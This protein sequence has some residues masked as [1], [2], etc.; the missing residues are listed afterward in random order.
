M[1]VKKNHQSKQPLAGHLTLGRRGEALAADYLTKIGFKI[2]ERNLRTRY[3]EIDLVCLDRQI[4]VFVEVKTRSS[5]SYAAPR[6]AVN[7]EKRRHLSKA[8]LWFI[9]QKAWEDRSARFDVVEISF[10]RPQAEINH[11]TNAF[12][13]VI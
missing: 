8:A 2:L 6:E 3:G 13:L 7:L 4:I 12:D 1:A 11:L 9:S 10:D 5:S